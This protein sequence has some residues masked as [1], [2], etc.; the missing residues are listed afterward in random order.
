MIFRYI[1]KELINIILEYDGR[2]IYKN[3]RYQINT[4]NKIYKSIK[5]N[6]KNKKFIL[7][8]LPKDYR[9][10]LSIKKIGCYNSSGKFSGFEKLEFISIGKK[11]YYVHNY[12][13]IMYNRNNNNNF[14]IDS[15]TLNFH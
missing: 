5:Q 9:T 3:N 14:L 4:D 2:I 15:R 8:I 7:N 1:P 11:P 13:I 10:L 12:I 6:I